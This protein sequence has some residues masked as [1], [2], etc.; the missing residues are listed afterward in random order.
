MTHNDL[1]K[2]ARRWLTS[3]AR[4]R[5]VLS[6]MRSVYAYEE[7]DAI[8]WRGTVSIVIECKTSRSDFRADRRKW[9]AK[10]SER[11]GAFRLY[12]TPPGLLRPEELPEGWGLLEAH[13][14]EVRQ[15]VSPPSWGRFWQE[16]RA[17]DR[18]FSGE[19]GIL[20]SAAKARS[21]TM[22]R[23]IREMIEDE[24]DVEKGE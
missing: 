12:M 6:E 17:E 2:R 5:Y 14:D 18:D 20:I 1:V 9:A 22:K 21:E 23:N 15:V 8:G 4:C 7:P 19:I 3:T 10:A 11:L 24:G 13:E 16:G